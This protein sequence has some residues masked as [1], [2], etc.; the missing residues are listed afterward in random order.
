MKRTRLA[1]SQSPR[2][3]ASRVA[4]YYNRRPGV[5]WRRWQP[6]GSMAGGHSVASGNSSLGPSALRYRYGRTNSQ[7]G[8]ARR[9]TRAPPRSR[10]R[11]PIHPSK[12]ARRRTK[13]IRPG[14]IPFGHRRAMPARGRPAPQTTLWKN[15]PDAITK[16]PAESGYVYPSV[17]SASP[18]T[19]HASQVLIGA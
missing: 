8:R 18:L 15:R 1:N 14:A 13:I 4:S 11:R 2:R 7:Y 6:C 16:S 3:A 5:D 9:R 19:Q 17:E 12:K 10:G